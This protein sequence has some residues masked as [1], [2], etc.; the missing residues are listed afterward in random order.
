MCDIVYNIYHKNTS[1]TAIGENVIIIIII[2]IKKTEHI[3]SSCVSI[4]EFMQNDPIM[5]EKVPRWLAGWL[6]RLLVGLVNPDVIFQLARTIPFIHLLNIINRL[7][8]RC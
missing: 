3:S 4:S 7:C 8:P 6:T 5:G 2:K 1:A